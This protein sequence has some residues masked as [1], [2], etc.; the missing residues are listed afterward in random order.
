MLYILWAIKYFGQ[1]DQFRV[2]NQFN[3]DI[4]VYT[5]TGSQSVIYRVVLRYIIYYFL[6]SSTY[7][8]IV[9]YFSFLHKIRLVKRNFSGWTMMFI[10]LECFIETNS[11]PY[12]CRSFYSQVKI[13][14]S[15]FPS[16]CLTNVGHGLPTLVTNIGYQ[17][18]LATLVTKLGYQH[19]LPMLN[20]G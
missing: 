3:N 4:T 12:I 6:E 1:C 13:Y 16:S 17:T 18:W 9:L 10:K 14:S 7:L 20:L 5:L 2:A 15:R 11:F 8:Y 19:W